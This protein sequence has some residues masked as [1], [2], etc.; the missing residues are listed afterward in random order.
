MK[1]LTLVL[2]LLLLALPMLA[3]D[4]GP[5]LSYQYDLERAERQFAPQWSPDGALLVWGA[6]EN[7]LSVKADGTDMRVLSE[8][9]DLYDADV[10]PSVSPDGSHIVYATFKHATSFVG[11]LRDWE[12]ESSRIDGSERRRL[13]KNSV[14]DV[15]PEWSPDGSR[16]AWVSGGSIRVMQPDGTNAREIAPS[17]TAMALPPQWSPDGRKI[18]FIAREERDPAEVKGSYTEYEYMLYVAAEDGS[19]LSR[20]SESWVVSPTWSPDGLHLAFVKSVGKA[21]SS[22][23]IAKAD[24][25]ESREL[26]SFTPGHNLSWSPSGDYIL[27][28]NGGVSIVAVTGSILQTFDGT[29]LI[30]L[31][32][33]QTEQ[34]SRSIVNTDQ[35][36]VLWESYSQWTRT[37]RTRACWQQRKHPAIGLRSMAGKYS[38]NTCPIQSIWILPRLLTATLAPPSA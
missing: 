14:E 9:R 5:G 36:T 28:S 15:N 38:R 22:T 31:R 29:V 12:I 21:R 35:E 33:R 27:F 13:T 24:G 4:C 34:A 16:I 2:K 19:G 8:S 30:M 3:S 18:A 17:I 26:I 6:G 10:S 37:V 32:G 1:R 7:I 11:D 23:Y 25:S 20:V